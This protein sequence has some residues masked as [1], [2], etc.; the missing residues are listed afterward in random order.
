LEDSSFRT[1]FGDVIDSFEKHLQAFSGA[2][3]ESSPSVF[4][5]KENPV[6][7]A[8]GFSMMVSSCRTPAGDGVVVIFGPKRMNYRRNLGLLDVLMDELK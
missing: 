6:S 7:A 3:A 5:G 8:R 4:I 1:Q 2:M